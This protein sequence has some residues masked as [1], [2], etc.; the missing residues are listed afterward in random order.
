MWFQYSTDDLENFR[1]HANIFPKP[2]ISKY[3]HSLLSG[4]HQNL[5]AFFSG[6]T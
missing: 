1:G 4:M 2:I 5:G 6:E 3:T